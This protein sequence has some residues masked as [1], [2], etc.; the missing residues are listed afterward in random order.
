MTSEA[1]A[2]IHI[3]PEAAHAFAIDVL[4]HSNVPHDRAI[5]VADSLV[6]ADLRGV[7][8]HG[9]N[10]LPG[11]IA[12][13]RSGVLTPS[14]SLEFQQKSPVM[15]SLDAQ[16]TFGFVAGRLAVDHAIGMATTFGVGIVG[17][18]NSGHYGMAATYLLRAMEKGL[19]AFAFT[20]ASRSMPVWGSKEPLLGTSPFAVGLPGGQNGNFVLDMS[21]S[22]VARVS[23]TCS[24][25]K[26]STDEYQGKVRKAARR[27]EKIPEGWMLDAEGQ[28]TTDP[29]E[30]LK[31]VVLPIGGPKG[32]G[33]AMMM[34]IFGG[35]LTGSAF[36]GDVHDQYKEF[37]RPQ[38]V[39]HWF[40]VFRPGM[41]LD[42]KEQYLQRMD[43]LLDRVRNSEKAAGV[44][45]IFTPGEIEDAKERAQ[46][47][48]G[49][50][51][52]A[53]E[54][55]ALNELAKEVSSDAKLE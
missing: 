34:D 7:D 16:N 27:G 36:G 5:M 26:Q 40:M 48:S 55:R 9:I 8:T 35:L 25:V 47:E 2:H 21:P 44:A 11:Y 30:A 23:I 13:V 6:R 33:L 1:S 50:P 53:S 24:G 17:V 20:N 37:D 54:I 46:R 3:S 29:V 42:S 52:T 31:G 4:T 18:K 32:S 10:R 12:R 45:Q 15:A 51:C 39:G 43:T 19:A 28:N 41:F 38:G 14:P 22:V 49:I